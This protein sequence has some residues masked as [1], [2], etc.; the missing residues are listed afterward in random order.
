MDDSNK[1]CGAAFHEAGHAV[2][3]WHLGVPVS[4]IAIGI[5]CD[6]TKG[7]AQIGSDQSHLPLIDRLAIWLAGIEAQDFF[8][9][10][11]HENAGT[12]DVDKA[13]QIV[14]EGVYDREIPEAEIQRLLD[15]GQARARELI[16]GNEVR[17]RRLAARLEERE[18]VSAEEFRHL[19]EE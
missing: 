7:Y 5:G 14:G 13:T 9:A 15:A 8:H 19:M 12:Y 11:T 2:V 3:A 6:D 10:P 4:D 16:V 17:C 1:A 18:Q